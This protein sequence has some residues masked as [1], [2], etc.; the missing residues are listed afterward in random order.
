MYENRSIRQKN[1]MWV[2]EWRILRGKAVKKNSL[3]SM[4]SDTYASAALLAEDTIYVVSRNHPTAGYLT[5]VDLDIAI[6]K[7]FTDF[8]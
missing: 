2:F 5:Y 7:I 3:F 6:V 8:F 1:L 4:I